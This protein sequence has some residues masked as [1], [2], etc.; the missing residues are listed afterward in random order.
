MKFLI[1][2]IIPEWEKFLNKSDKYI[3][4]KDADINNYDKEQFKIMPIYVIDYFKYNNYENNIFKNN[5]SNIELLDNKSQFAKYMGINFP[6]YI[7]KTYYYNFNSETFISETLPFE[8]MIMKPNV[9]F[10][11][12]GIKIFN[13][14]NQMYNEVKKDHIIQKFIPH[15]N[16]F[17]GH[18]LV[19]NGMI[20]K[21]IYFS[22]KT[23]NNILKG[24]ITNY[25]IIT[26]IL[27][28]DDIFNK[29]F[30]NLNYSGF[31]CADFIIINNTIIIFE[32]NPRPGGSLIHNEKYFNIFVDKLLEIIS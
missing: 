3:C 18:F 30:N 28:D 10:A 21:K 32:I 24:R 6:N 29:I 7:P 27:I 17:V 12:K 13:N 8:K 14:K 26:N 5:L 16:C 31:A 15:T 25:D 1:I 22:S 11:G 4:I 2:D 20:H 23:R 19:L 9:N